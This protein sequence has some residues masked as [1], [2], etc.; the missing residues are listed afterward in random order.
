MSKKFF[1]YELDN[2]PCLF[3]DTG[4]KAEANAQAKLVQAITGP[5]T[6]IFPNGDIEIWVPEGAAELESLNEVGLTEGNMVIWGPDFPGESL[7]EIINDPH[8]NKEAF[9]LFRFWLKARITLD[10]TEELEPSFPGPMGS[11]IISGNSQEYN[12]NSK[13]PV[14]TVF[15]PP[16]QIVKRTLDR[17]G[18]SAEYEALRYI[19]PDLEISVWI[20]SPEKNPESIAFSAG[21]ILYQ[22]FCG[23]HPFSGGNYI[24][25][26]M[27]DRASKSVKETWKGRQ[28]KETALDILRQDI[29][30]AVYIPPELAAPGLDPELSSLIN[31]A[32]SPV[33][34][35]KKGKEKIR[36]SNRPSP[37][38]IRDFISPPFSKPLNSWFNEFDR[39]EFKKAE[40][41]RELFTKKN[42]RQVKTR[43]FFQ[44]NNQRIAGTLIAMLV[45]TL[46]IRGFINH[47]AT[48]PNTRGLTPL[49]VAETYYGA[50]GELDHM[51]M[52][53]C[54]VGRVGRNDIEMV[55]AIYVAS[56]QIQSQEMGY[57]FYS[58]QRWLDAGSPERVVDIFGVTHLS[59]EI[60]SQNEETVI[61]KTEFTLWMPGA[62]TIHYNPADVSEIIHIGI[63]PPESHHFSDMLELS[64]RRDSW[65]ITGIERTSLSART[66]SFWLTDEW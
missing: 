56:R 37:Q 21:V 18:E 60:L 63:I 61:M 36:V 14:G 51:L 25:P 31:R 59:A 53:A 34:Y 24:N 3:F 7:A 39:D 38:E 26:V 49:E 23:F 46:G 44:R 32:L 47:Q 27:G 40:A 12:R 22:I 10:E 29:R 57:N 4:L 13:Y 64:W 50:F 16:A 35:K 52:E 42:E 62:V 55:I 33:V 9:E 11:I 58:A 65:R 8:R 1:S 6:I 17:D 15:F 66:D 2:K 28:V 20:S 54:I 41:N 45:L 5:G 19:H 48:L 30:E 43:R